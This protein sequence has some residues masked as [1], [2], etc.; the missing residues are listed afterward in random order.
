MG[1]AKRKITELNKKY[2][3]ERERKS[4]VVTSAMQALNFW[5]VTMVNAEQALY[6]QLQQEYRIVTARLSITDWLAISPIR[7]IRYAVNKLFVRGRKLDIHRRYEE[8][9]FRYDKIKVENI[10]GGEEKMSAAQIARKL[11]LPDD[12]IAEILDKIVEERTPKQP[13]VEKE[14]Q[15]EK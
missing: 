1:T 7:F 5:K 6:S 10:L 11:D 15:G 12:R 14:Q 8:H 13:E 9:Q 3:K 4:E 2:R